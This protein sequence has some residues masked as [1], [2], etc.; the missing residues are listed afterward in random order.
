MTKRTL[1]II[2]AI[3]AVLDIAAG[4]WYL[5]SH[6]NSDGKSGELFEN[7]RQAVDADT[8]SESIVP[9]KFKIIEKQGYFVSKEPSKQG[10]YRT[11]WSSVKRFKGRIPVTINGST[12][13]NSLMAEITRKTFGFNDPSLE[14]HINAFTKEPVFNTKED[15][16]YKKM[17]KKP[18]TEDHYGNVQ[19]IKVYPTFNS[20]HILVMVIDQTTFNGDYFQ[21]KMQFVTFNRLRQQVMTND[22]IINYNESSEILNLVN[23]NIDKLKEEG[24]DLHHAI[25]LP[26]EIY[27]RRNGIFFIFPA[28]T[29]ASL[30]DG[31]Q[32]IFVYYKQ[33]KPY[34]TKD[35]RHIVEHNNGFWH[36][37]P[38]SFN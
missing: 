23:E 13:I 9:D 10:H 1:I 36:Y 18:F 33:L 6:V 16:D 28:G 27:V 14:T 15:V 12:A 34:L 20:N 11:Y 26:S 31:M 3:L 32:E 22:E 37:N 21:E 35:F 38:I 8:I 2:I 24:H 25:H 17:L 29:I 5:A 4:F 30:N 19:N 7:D